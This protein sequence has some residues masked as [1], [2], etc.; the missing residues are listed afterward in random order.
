MA[1][2][3]QGLARLFG[4]GSVLLLA[5]LLTAGIGRAVERTAT[6]TNTPVFD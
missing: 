3:Q 4:L 5:V 6:Y 2:K 1:A